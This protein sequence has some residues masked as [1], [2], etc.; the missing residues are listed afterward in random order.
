MAE[1]ASG[2]PL[3]APAAAPSPAAADHAA[4]V[5]ARIDKAKRYPAAALAAGQTGLVRL[6]L[7][8]ARDGTLLAAAVETGSGHPLLDA[9]ALAAAR[10]AAPYPAAPPEL[11]ESRLEYLIPIRFTR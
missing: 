9:A 7:G 11:D 4:A 5:R 1:G 10:A 8:L 3:A 2:G 6:R